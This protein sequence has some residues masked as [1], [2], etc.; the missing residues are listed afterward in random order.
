MKNI[1]STD[2]SLQ[3]ALKK[4]EETELSLKEKIAQVKTEQRAIDNLTK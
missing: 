4:S 2:S 3:K 1:A